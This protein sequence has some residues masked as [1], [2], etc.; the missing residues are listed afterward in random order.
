MRQRFADDMLV[1]KGWKEAG[2]RGQIKRFV[3]WNQWDVGVNNGGTINTPKMAM[4]TKC[5][6]SQHV[7]NEKNGVKRRAMRRRA[8]SLLYGSV[9]REVSCTVASAMG[10]Y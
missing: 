4:I 5:D 2:I 7:M 9:Q 3:D 6:S 10:L 8:V 1:T